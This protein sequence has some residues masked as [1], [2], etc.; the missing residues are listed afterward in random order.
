MRRRIR[1]LFTI[2]VPVVALACAPLPGIVGA[3]DSV[4]EVLCETREALH[5]AR[6]SLQQGDVMAAIDQLKAYL[7]EH[8]HDEEVAAALQLLEAQVHKLEHSAQR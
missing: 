8:G 6:R 4:L 5:G 1:R 3:V 2:L 7:V